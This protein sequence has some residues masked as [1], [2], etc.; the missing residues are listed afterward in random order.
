MSITGA[1]GSNI[2]PLVLVLSYDADGELQIEQSVVC[3]LSTRFESGAEST[4]D[5]EA[6]YPHPNN[7]PVTKSI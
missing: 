6:K 5:Q 2:Q 7:Q 4:S 3:H 1:E